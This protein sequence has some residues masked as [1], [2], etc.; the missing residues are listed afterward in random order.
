MNTVEYGPFPHQIS[1]RLDLY[2]ATMGETAFETEPDAKVT[3][4]FKNR[5]SEQL[6]QFVD[7]QHLQDR[8]DAI[9]SLGFSDDELAYIAS[10]A[11]EGRP[12]CTDEY[13]AY[14]RDNPLPPVRVS[15][16]SQ[17]TDLHI[18][19]TGDW[20]IVTFWET[21]VM[22]EVNELYFEE[23]TQRNGMHVMDLYDE[24]DRRLSEKIELLREHPDIRF[25]DFGT[26]RH[27]SYRWQRHVVER[28]MNE[29]PDQFIGTSNLALAHEFGLRPIGTYAHEMLMVNA[30]LADARGKDIR[31]SHN[32]TMQNW[33]NSHGE[34][35]TIALTDTYSTDFFFSDFTPE[36]A[37]TWR[38]LR[39][40]SG[41]PY[42]FGEKAITFYE[43]LGIDPHTKT[44]VFS[45]G[46]DIQQII[47]LQQRFAGRINVLFGWGT[48]LTNDLGLKALNIV[49]K[50]TEVD[51]AHA[52]KFSDVTTKYTGDPET[53]ERY[54]H[55]FIRNPESIVRTAA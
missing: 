41:D 47:A 5:G 31:A 25:A 15:I 4:T 26:R 10:I 54:T 50:A 23:Y 36:Q 40:D 7:A 11:F 2:K 43:S 55:V 34:P 38:G 32:Q 53:I 18:E 49:M 24:G 3:F 42:D 1:E 17:S 21:V 6:S 19:A 52:V 35:L 48:T 45:D 44:L 9:A 37:A 12:I 33:Y 51:G 22:S 30:A 29:C 28:L 20:P 46:L 8:L 13:I 14:L 16:D 39:H 27:F